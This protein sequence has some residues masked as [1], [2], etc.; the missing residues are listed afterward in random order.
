MVIPTTIQ[1]TVDSLRNGA[2]IIWAYLQSSFGINLHDCTQSC[3]RIRSLVVKETEAVG[4]SITILIIQVQQEL[5]I[6]F[7]FGLKEILFN[8]MHGICF[9]YECRIGLSLKFQRLNFT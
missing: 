8:F 6:K 9:D 3:W 1:E 4:L 5:I 2:S 7:S